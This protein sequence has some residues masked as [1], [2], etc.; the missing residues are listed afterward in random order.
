MTHKALPHPDQLALDWE[1]DPAI[2]ALIEARVA[3][4]AEAVAFQWRLRLVGIETCM[5]GSLVIAAGLAL[6]QPPLQTIRT[7]LIVAAACFA[8]GMLLIGLSGACGMLL[9][10]LSRWRRK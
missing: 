7:G 5:M 10:R 4:R 9:T 2:E 1:N 6:D 8:S 3:K